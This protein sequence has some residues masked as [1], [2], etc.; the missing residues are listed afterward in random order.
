MQNQLDPNNPVKEY[1]GVWIPAEVMES[2]E[3]SPIDKLVYG[4]IACF[5]ECY[6][7]NAWLAKRICRSE[8]TARRSVAHLIELGFVEECG[9]NGRFRVVKITR[10]CSKMNTTL[11]KNE[12]SDC[13]KMNTIDK[14]KDKRIILDTKVSNTETAVSEPVEYGNPAINAALNDFESVTGF[15]P[16]NNKL[17][18]FAAQRLLKRFTPTQLHT[19]YQLV[20]KSSNQRFAPVITDLKSL[21]DNLEKLKVWYNRQRPQSS[22]RVKSIESEPIK[23]VNIVEGF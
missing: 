16:K 8:M 6:A 13:S 15:K 9:Y 1:T 4:E 17:N 14:S 2:T 5:K 20:A 10:P 18:R 11:F 12:Q 22:N 3:L 23:V 21:E 7:S 19:L